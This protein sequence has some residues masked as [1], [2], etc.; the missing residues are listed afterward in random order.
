MAVEIVALTG[1]DWLAEVLA[2][3]HAEEWGHLYDPQ[4]WNERIGVAEFLAMAQPGST[5]QTWVAFDGPAR[6]AGALLGSVS[7]LG[8][9]DLPGFE[10]LTPWLASLFIAPAARGHRLGAAL[11]ERVLDHARAA[12]HVAVH[13]FTAGQEDYYLHRGWRTIDRVEHRGQRTSV[14]MRAT[15][16]TAARRAVTSHWC[17]DPDTNGAYSYLRPGG[18]PAHRDTLAGPVQ[19]GLWLAGEACSRSYPG[20]MHGAWFEGERAAEAAIVESSQVVPELPGLPELPVLVIGAGLA[21]LAAARRLTEAGRQVIVLEATDHLGG[22]ATVD[23]SLGIPLPLGGAWLHGDVG[24]PLAPFVTTIPEDWTDSLT[25][26][27]GHG[28]VGVADQQAALAARPR[29]EAMLKAAAPGTA[30]APVL[31]Q[32]IDS[33]TG[34][35]DLQRNVLEGWFVREIENL[36]AA[37][38][39]DFSAE[40]GWEPYELPGDDCFITSSLA[41]VFDQ[42]AAGLDVRFEHRV[43]SL[44]WGA[45]GWRTDT[46]VSASQVIVTIPIG[47]SEPGGSA[48]SRRCPPT[49]STP[50]ITSALDR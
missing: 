50:S 40:A 3:W 32:A 11:V 12:G 31:R 33:L 9:D 19:P 38:V 44:T 39:G 1:L 26:L 5:D 22:R 27:A 35:T 28:R 20:T 2:G 42:L 47:A 16:P 49:C 17:A 7:L 21:G 4:V 41:S 48:S 8:T 10:H 37:P 23:T 29:V 45:D 13:L 34:L 14:M 30:A 36:Y 25:Y 24:H 15:S 46:G 6:T 18:R 43:G